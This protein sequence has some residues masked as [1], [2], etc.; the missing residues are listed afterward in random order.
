MTG[1][2]CLLS[3]LLLSLAA[4]AF[5]GVG[6][7]PQVGYYKSS[8]ADEGEF[9]YG[10]ALRL[11]PVPFL[12]LEGSV[13]YRQESYYDDALTVKSWPIMAT[14]LLYPVPVAYG[15]AGVGWYNTTFEYDLQHF[16]GA[17]EE[18][19]TNEFGWHFGAGVELPL[20]DA[21]R[22]AGDI[23]YVFLD[24]EFEDLPGSDEAESNFYVLTVTLLF[25]GR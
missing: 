10:G 14:A 16:T 3:L 19:T 21:L 20:G 1:K 5:A 22:L 4:P 11:T 15:L 25:G 18:E 12:G 8:D 9:M 23:R 13:N 6:I 7:G 2:R 24:Y 17:D